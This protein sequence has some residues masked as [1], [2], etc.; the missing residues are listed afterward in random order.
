MSSREFG[1]GG[2]T[3]ERVDEVEDY[4]EKLRAKYGQLGGEGDRPGAS[5]AI[6]QPRVAEAEREPGAEDSQVGEEELER[7]RQHV[8]EKYPTGEGATVDR[9]A[10]KVDENKAAEVS[11]YE[12]EEEFLAEKEEEERELAEAERQR[13]LEEDGDPKAADSG[14]ERAAGSA[15]L[16]REGGG[17]EGRPDYQEMTHLRDQS[18]SKRREAENI[19]QRETLDGES[20]PESLATFEAT[21]QRTSDGKWVRFE[22][23]LETFQERIGMKFEEGR[24][25][26]ITG[27]IGDV[28][29]RMTHFRGEGKYLYITPPRET[30]KM[31]EAG[32]KYEITVNSVEE[33]RRFEVSHDGDVTR[34]TLT[35]RALESAQKSTEAMKKAD[36]G[37]RIVEFTLRN[38]SHEGEGSKRLFAKVNTN[39]GAV[40]MN[41]GR[42]GAEK[43]DIMDSR[44]S[45]TISH[46]QLCRGFQRP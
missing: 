42:A 3:G 31:F 15:E 2:E 21:A 45:E 39:E 11:T 9:S 17:N 37:D 38:L 26:V 24:T 41:V 10:E 8:K 30:M 43:G 16:A 32:R 13:R 19:E 29:F 27:T 20:K 1:D 6:E 33:K 23:M 35:T 28:E 22:V 12:N 40:M 25:Y 4:R 44:E 7:L 5:A 18:P 14:A 46:R 36:E 34:L